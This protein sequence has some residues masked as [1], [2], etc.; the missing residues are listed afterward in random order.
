MFD[1]SAAFTVNSVDAATLKLHFS[2]SLPQTIVD[3]IHPTGVC[4]SNPILVV[5]RRD[6]EVRP[7]SSPPTSVLQSVRSLRPYP[8]VAGEPRAI[9]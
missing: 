9:H 4:F 2:L 3:S 6:E 7:S 5:T 8:V 1:C